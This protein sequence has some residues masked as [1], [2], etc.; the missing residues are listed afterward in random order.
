M[1]NN[2]LTNYDKFFPIWNL[3]SYETKCRFINEFIDT[4]KVKVDGRKNVKVDIIH[5]KL[6]PNRIRKLSEL[7]LNNMIDEISE[8][9][10]ED[11]S[12][13][14]FKN[15][16]EARKYIDILRKKHHISILEVDPKNDYVEPSKLFKIINVKPTRVIEKPKIFLLS[17]TDEDTW[18]KEI[19][20]SLKD[21][22]KRKKLLTAL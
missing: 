1:I 18:R 19:D 21:K 22:F 9:Q 7:K 3:V 8:H 16:T 6:K 4:I 2:K 5:L 12:T 14:E 10:G 17:I 11:I 20:D 15:E 13:A